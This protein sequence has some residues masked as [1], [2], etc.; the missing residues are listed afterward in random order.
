MLKIFQSLHI[1]TAMCTQ[2]LCFV[3]QKQA[4][5]TVGGKAHLS[6]VLH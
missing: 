1:M 4:S 6:T 5:L 2:T 3:R